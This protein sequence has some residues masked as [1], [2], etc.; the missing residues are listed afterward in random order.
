MATLSRRRTLFDVDG[1]A[2]DAMIGSDRWLFRADAIG[3]RAGGRR[4]K[5][6][7]WMRR[8]SSPVG[9]VLLPARNLRPSHRHPST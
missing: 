5:D 3:L 9:P 4:W 6:G 1:L 8:V 7:R 2:P